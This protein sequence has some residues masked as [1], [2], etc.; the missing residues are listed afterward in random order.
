L[1]LLSRNW[2]E[3]RA[4]SFKIS[5]ASDE[6]G[7]DLFVAAR[8]LAEQGADL[9]SS[10]GRARFAVRLPTAVDSTSEVAE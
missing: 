3:V 2:E 8:L 5:S 4:E 7:V 1:P 9:W 6:G 10:A